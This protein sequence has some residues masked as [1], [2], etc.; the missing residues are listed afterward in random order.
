MSDAEQQGGAGQQKPIPGR[1][2]GEV[3]AVLARLHEA[4]AKPE[5][6]RSF[7]ADPRS[8]VE[9]Y[10]LLPESVRNAFDVMGEHELEHVSTVV[11]ALMREGFYHEDE[12]GRVA[13]F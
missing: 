1:A 10:D 8:T 7:N 2:S 6:R 11:D 3:M 5:G 13:F 4:L 9:G 12:F